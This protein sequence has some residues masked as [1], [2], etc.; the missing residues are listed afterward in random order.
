MRNSGAGY[1]EA[2]RV[3]IELREVADQFKETQEFQERFRA[4]VRAH[5][6]RL[7]FVKRLQIASSHCQKRKRYCQRG[8]FA[9]HRARKGYFY[10]IV[11]FSF[12]VTRFPLIVSYRQF[13]DLGN[14]AS[15][16][17]R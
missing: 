5:L 12:L 16:L 1:D 8:C 7:A 4:W 10:D 11:L 3:L 6:R 17:L 9:K 2:V 13:G 14:T 15:L